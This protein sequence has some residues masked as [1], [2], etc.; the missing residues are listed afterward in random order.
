LGFLH[1][2]ATFTADLNLLVQAGMGVALLAG[3]RLARLRRFRA[4]GRCQATVLLLNLVM[5]S[6]VMAPSFRSQVSPNLQKA[7]GDL[8]Y[9]LPALHAALGTIAELLGLY[10]VLVATGAPVVPVRFRFTDY[11]RWMRT[12]LVLWWIVLALGTGLYFVWYRGEPL[13]REDPGASGGAAV[14][15]V[16]VQ[17]FTFEPKELTVH[18]GTTVTWNDVGG[19]HT[20]ESADG[21]LKSDTLVA[22]QAYQKRFDAPGVYD[23]YCGNH[24]TKS[25]TGMTGRVV[26]TAR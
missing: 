16:T 18:V 11:R 9:A 4:H 25:G 2:G 23:Y 13:G 21:F 15:T 5:I 17:N 6:L 26:V 20:V 14:A 12:T 3:A 8:Y 19:R 24:G 1:T 22:G 7:G 10:V